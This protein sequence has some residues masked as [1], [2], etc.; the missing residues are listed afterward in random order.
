VLRSYHKTNGISSLL[1]VRTAFFC[2]NKLCPDY[3][4]K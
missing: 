4:Q 3:K 1:A 2:G